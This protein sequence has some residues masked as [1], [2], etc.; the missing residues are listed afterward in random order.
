MSERTVYPATPSGK[1]GVLPAE[2]QVSVPW[3]VVHD[4]VALP[5]EQQCWG[6]QVAVAENYHFEPQHCDIQE[7]VMWRVVDD[8]VS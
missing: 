5:D 2:R 7:G 1:L 4:E 8:L 6:G 3:C